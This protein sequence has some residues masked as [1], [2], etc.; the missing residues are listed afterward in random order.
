MQMKNKLSRVIANN[1]FMLKYIFRFTPGLLVYVVFLKILTAIAQVLSSVFT[2][3]FLIDSYQMNRPMSEVVLYLVGYVIFNLINTIF[4]SIYKEIYLPKMKLVLAEKM[5]TELYLKAISMDLKNYDDSDFYN[6]FIWAMSQSEGQAVSVL[7]SLGAFI[8]CTTAILGV[9]AIILTLDPIGIIFAIVSFVLRF[10]VTFRENKIQYEMDLETKEVQRHRDYTNRVF[11]QL[12]FIKEIRL[13]HVEEKLTDDFKRHN[14]NLMSRLRYY[15]HKLLKLDFIKLIFSRNVL[16]NG[17][18]MFVVLYKAIVL[19]SLTYGAVIGLLN[20]TRNLQMNLLNMART[21]PKFSQQSLYIE[22]FRKFLDH[23]N[24]IKE[25]PEGLKIGADFDEIE[26]KNVNFTYESNEAPTLK[27]INIKIKAGQKIALVGYN[28][29]G[30]STLIKLILR[31]YEVNDGTV[32]VN[33]KNIKE[34]CLKDYRDLF[35][36]VFQDYK[37]FAAA[38]SENVKMDLIDGEKDR[39][40]VVEALEKSGFSNKLSKIEDG[41]DAPLTREFS[42]KGIE[43]SGGE[44]QKIAIARVFAKDCQIVVLDEPSSAL[45]PISEYEINQK[46]MNAADHKT[47]I[48]ISHRLST[49]VIADKIYM[50]ENGEIIEEGSHSELMKKN[51][52]YAEMFNLQAEKYRAE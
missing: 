20:G 49:T 3:T 40:E 47:V 43:L 13:S 22:R 5:Q 35:G 21:I 12:D 38:I 45:D 39:K 24:E 29:A 19:Q 37:L 52:K 4:N 17:V 48:F 42:K 11:Y 25:N 8:Q 44:A 1:L 26:L 18:Y 9:G 51:G 46:M 2:M 16:I 10:M 50:L 7:E 14:K 27:N 33:G 23:E 6:D 36:V 15:A 28:G 30:K 32:L 34:Y 41:I 31:L